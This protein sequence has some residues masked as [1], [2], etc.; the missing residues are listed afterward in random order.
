[1]ITR[2]IN[3]AKNPRWA[4]PT[5]YRI[6]LDVDFD[7]LDYEYVEFTAVKNTPQ[8]PDYEYSHSLFERAISGE[9]G[10]IADFVKEPNII[11]TN[12]IDLL[13][14]VRDDLLKQTDYIENPTKWNRLSEDEQLAWTE[15]RNALRDLPKNVPNPEFTWEYIIEGPD[16]YRRVLPVNFTLPVEVK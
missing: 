14:I 4:D 2:T 11:G 5:G 3:D 10:P 12:A 8:T 13:R 7:E 15:Y 16:Y 6:T 9:F 1:M